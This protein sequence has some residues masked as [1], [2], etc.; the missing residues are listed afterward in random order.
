MKLF[1]L[2]IPKRITPSE[3]INRVNNSMQHIKALS[4]KEE[5][6]IERLTNVVIHQ[7]CPRQVGDVIALHNH[8]EGWTE[9]KILRIFPEI[10][11]KNKTMRWKYIGEFSGHKIQ[12]GH[13]L[14]HQIE[15][16]TKDKVEEAG[17]QV[18]AQS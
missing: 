1:N 3:F 4:D 5:E 18:A 8:P 7:H 11:W 6:Y 17:S 2:R 13:L 9:L 10:N 12:E 16:F 15:E 14:D